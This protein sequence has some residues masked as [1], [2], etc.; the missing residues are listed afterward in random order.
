MGRRDFAPPP[1]TLGLKPLCT[2]AAGLTAL[3]SAL[4]VTAGWV[5][6][7]AA[8]L[9]KAGEVAEATER[10]KLLEVSV[11]FMGRILGV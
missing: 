8:T 10:L 3:F 6:T 1:I 11:K 7:E 4:A 9:L 2:E 5:P